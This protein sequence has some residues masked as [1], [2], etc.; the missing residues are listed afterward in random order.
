[1]LAFLRKGLAVSIGGARLVEEQSSGDVWLS[2]PRDDHAGVRIVEAILRNEHL[3]KLSPARAVRC[4][5]PNHVASP[6]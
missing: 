1:M 5:L 2:F 6:T 4:H 3:F